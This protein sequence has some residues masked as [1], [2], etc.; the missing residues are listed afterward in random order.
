MNNP[1]K[2]K[3]LKT[4]NILK[5]IFKSSPVVGTTRT[6]SFKIVPKGEFK[7]RLNEWFNQISEVKFL[8]IMDIYERFKNN[9]RNIFKI[10]INYSNLYKGSFLF[11]KLRSRYNILN[12]KIEE[13]IRQDIEGTLKSF[14][15]NTERLWKNNL[16]VLDN[17]LK[18]INEIGSNLISKFD[19]IK[20]D[21]ESLKNN[22]ENIFNRIKSINYPF[23]NYEK[24][25]ETKNLVKEANN[26]I[27]EFNSFLNIII[28][29]TKLKRIKL[30]KLSKLPRFPLVERY[31]NIEDFRNRFN[32]KLLEEVKADFEKRIK[33]IKEK[34]NIINVLSEKD[35]TL[36]KLEKYL[37]LNK[38]EE[39]IE[40][41]VKKLEKRSRYIKRKSNKFEDRFLYWI[42]N[43]KP[44]IND[45][46]N[47]LVKRLEKEEQHVRKKITDKN[48]V[49]SY[50]NTLLIFI[51]LIYVSQLKKDGQIT[52]LKQ[53]NNEITQLKALLSKGKSIKDVFTISGFS[54]NKYKPQKAACLIIDSKN[55]KTKLGIV[56][57]TSQA[58]FCFKD[59][60]LDGSQEK[61]NFIV[62]VGGGRRKKEAKPKQMRIKIGH[63]ELNKDNFACYFWLYQ[64]KSYLRRFLFN[65]HWGFLNNNNTNK[66]F[67]TNARVKRIKNKP[68]DKFEYYVDISFMYEGDT[69]NLQKHLDYQYFIGMD[70]GEKKPIT[71]VVIDKN[72]K[73]IEK[74]HFGEELI[75]KLEELNKLRKK[76]KRIHNKIKRTQETIIKQSISKILL[77]LTK[78]PGLIFLENLKR[79]F[80]KSKSLI[81]KRTYSKVEEYLKN[82]LQ[83]INLQFLIKKVNPKDTSIICPKCDF[84]FNKEIKR[85]KIN[86][87]NQE[88]MIEIINNLTTKE[89]FYYS[90]QLSILIPQK[91]VSYNE[92]EKYPEEI[93]I[94]N[95][96]Q[97][98]KENKLEEA[99]RYFKTITPRITQDKFVCLRCG[100]KEDADVVG[101]IN[102]AKIGLKRYFKNT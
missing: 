99:L 25:Y 61:I 48:S 32:L 60:H 75:K 49:N 3:F 56:L 96:K 41:K 100:Y 51:E 8:H 9:E 6:V 29:K 52:A 16:S 45:I 71:Y 98:I 42:L 14:T 34:Y 82:A 76:G 59:R 86:K 40:E 55:N 78:Y 65:T 19:Y 23:E 1:N 46:I 72:G 4:L 11:K 85:E 28:T 36:E 62:L 31:R 2:N 81:A 88:K 92:N 7:D 44:K 35:I 79:G 17:N 33:D 30:E 38:L 101:A 50:F 24:W 20:E 37:N 67:P 68:G 10:K 93:S 13:G 63:L 97:D 70:R 95:I 73:I 94:E 83:L 15:T 57:A 39:Y 21:I 26:Y 54:W 77:L 64:G 102:I 53:I 12:S 90:P 22:L 89:N 91:W 66:F 84:N 5:N 80:G 47:G 27:K 18:K 58:V 87:M 74:N 43:R 69:N